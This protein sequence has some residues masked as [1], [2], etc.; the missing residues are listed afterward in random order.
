MLLCCCCWAAAAERA[1][2]AEGASGSTATQPP[3][4]S[5]DASGSQSLDP[6]IM[7][8][9][10]QLATAQA[11]LPLT[12]TMIDHIIMNPMLHA[13]LRGA[14]LGASH[15]GVCNYHLSIAARI[16]LQHEPR[17]ALSTGR[18]RDYRR[19]SWLTLRST[20]LSAWQCD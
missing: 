10:Q 15:A 13:K 3:S 6:V 4:N 2:D 1:E 5:Q 17:A 11:S 7:A 18:S 20:S 16:A 12:G 14:S 19:W 8:Q 9:A